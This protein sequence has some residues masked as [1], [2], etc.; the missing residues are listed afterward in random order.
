MTKKVPVLF[1]TDPEAS[2][3]YEKD[4]NLYSLP[5]YYFRKVLG[6]PATKQDTRHPVFFEEPE[7]K[8][9]EDGANFEFTILPSHNPKDLFDRVQECSRLVSERILSQF[10]EHCLPNLHFLPTVN[11][12]IERWADMP[13]DFVV[14]TEF[15]CDPDEDVFDLDA[16]AKVMDA[17]LH[18]ERY[19]GGHIHVSGSAW[20][21]EDPHL[22]V[23]C[24]L[25]TAGMASIRYSDVPDLE[26]RRLFLYGRPGKFRVQEYGKRNMFGPDYAIGIEY[27][28]PSARW[29]GDW[30]IAEKVLGWAEIGIKGLLETGLGAELAPEIT[31]PAIDAIMN[32]DQDAAGT[33]LAYIESRL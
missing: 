6:V 7:M 23:K 26:R 15:G 22:A 18:P 8:A 29:A 9:I 2:A 19:D 10:P 12:D 27:R 14:A 20:I 25:Y 24:M 30:N 33:I 5:P 21:A 3:V 16:A 28:T 4:G 13:L 1:G 17:S 31:Q 32:A 11:W